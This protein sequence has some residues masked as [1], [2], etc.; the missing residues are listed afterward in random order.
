MPFG[1]E[2]AGQAGPAGQ[3]DRLRDA[4]D[5]QSIVDRVIEHRQ[6]LLNPRSTDLAFDGGTPLREHALKRAERD[7]EF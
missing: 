6:G 4:V 2:G 5:A 3:P 1:G 7:V